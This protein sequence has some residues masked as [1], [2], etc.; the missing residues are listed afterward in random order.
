MKKQPHVLRNHTSPSFCLECTPV[1]FCMG[2]SYEPQKFYCGKTKITF[3]AAQKLE[4]WDSAGKRICPVSLGVTEVLAF[5][6]LSLVSK[7]RRTQA[8]CSPQSMDAANPCEP[9]WELGDWTAPF[10][11][12]CERWPSRPRHHRFFG[13]YAMNLSSKS[14][15]ARPTWRCCNSENGSTT[16]PTIPTIKETIL[17]PQHKFVAQHGNNQRACVFVVRIFSQPTTV[18]QWSCWICSVE[19][20]PPLAFQQGNLGFQLRLPV[21]GS[22]KNNSDD[23]KIKVLQAVYSLSISNW[24]H[25]ILTHLLTCGLCLYVRVGVNQFNQKPSTIE[26]VRVK[27]RNMCLQKFRDKSPS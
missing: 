25:S 14:M 9:S 21:A 11:E 17:A 7:L 13:S 18:M 4:V 22:I 23:I 1:V 5:K 19:P 26:T 16:H 6:R 10:T 3:E 20:F 2:A 8:A 24:S 15:P 27:E 12:S